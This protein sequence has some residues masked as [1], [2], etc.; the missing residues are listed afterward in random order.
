[1]MAILSWVGRV[2]KVGFLDAT[3]V[4]TVAVGTKEKPLP[5]RCPDFL[6]RLTATLSTLRRP[7][8][9][10]LRQ[11]LVDLAAEPD[12]LAPLAG[13]PGIYPYGRK[14]LYSANGV[15][16]IVMNWAAGRECS[17]HDHGRS[18]GWIHVVSGT[19][20][21]RLHT[22]DQDDIPVSFA[23]RTE[24][25]GT[26]M[27]APRGAVHSMGNL[28]GEPTLTLHLYAPPIQAM[29]VWDLERCAM[30][31]VSDDCG[32]WW[33]EDQRQR[34]QEIKLHRTAAGVAS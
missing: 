8:P 2:P 32:A 31:V 9:A 11:A 23:T 30:C 5:T 29:K 6:D 7:G 26:V 34:L 14:P 17:P 24:P 20:L 28:T 27:F 25:T 4:H 21:H 22:L 33:P 10:Q 3:V 12:D 1:M 15:E 19:I 16:A 18:F 13:D